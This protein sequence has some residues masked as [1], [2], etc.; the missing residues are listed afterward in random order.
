MPRVRYS[1]FFDG[2]TGAQRVVI[3]E[4]WLGRRTSAPLVL[5]WEP[6]GWGRERRAADALA[7][8][9]LADYSRRRPETCDVRVVLAGYRDF[10]AQFLDHL[11]PDDT[12]TIRDQDVDLWIRVWRMLNAE[13]GVGSAY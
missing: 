13:E 4:T 8:S 1:G 3:T 9:V 11:R 12:W 5:A 10:R 6:A 7:Y 2:R